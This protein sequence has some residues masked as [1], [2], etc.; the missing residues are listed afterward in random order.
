MKTKLILTAATLSVLCVFYSNRLAKAVESN[1][2]ST[3][4]P[5]TNAPSSVFTANQAPPNGNRTTPQPGRLKSVYNRFVIDNTRQ[6]EVIGRKGTKL[7]FP[8]RA[9]VDENGVAVEGMVEVV[10]KECYGLDEI[11]AEKLSTTSGAQIIETAGMVHIEAKQAGRSLKLN[12]EEQYTVYFPNGGK[13]G[14]G[15]QLFYGSPTPQGIIDW[16]PA[17]TALGTQVSATSSLQSTAIRYDCFIQICESEF[18]RGTQISEMDYFNWQLQDGQ[19]LNQWFVSNFNPDASM[20]DEFC[21]DKLISRIAFH[22]NADGGFKD[23]YI[24][25]ESQPSY[26]RVIADFLSTMPPLDLSKVMPVYSSDHLCILTFGHKQG[27]TSDDF[28][29]R[30]VKRYDSKT[31]DTPMTDVAASDLDY[32]M[33]TSTELGWLNCDRFLMEERP[34][35]EFR[36]KASTSPGASVSMV[37]ED[38]KSI[39]RGV[40][41]GDEFVFSYVPEGQKIR[42]LAVDNNGGSP[43]MQEARTITSKRPFRMG[44]YE[45]MTLAKLDA[46]MCW[47]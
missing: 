12:N 37:F 7:V 40:P 42:L 45:P 26:D 31:A 21:S 38:R 9:F 20:V 44:S 25:H 6:S 2:A 41:I 29:K 23:Y 28:I 33:F 36:V 1:S 43:M 15:F 24:A 14:D 10:M 4:A 8:A 47:K 32:Y 22:V 19:T 39:V 46:A 16:T 3:D 11:L 35:V 30:F 34:L 17:L 13:K 18:R 27:S 5:A